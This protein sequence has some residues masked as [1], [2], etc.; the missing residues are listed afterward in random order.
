MKKV[1]ASFAAASLLALVSGAQAQQATAARVVASTT[2]AGAF[3]KAAGATDVVVIAPADF[4][5]PPDYDPRPSDLAAIAGAKFVVMAPFDGFA[6]RLQEAT[7]SAAQIVT[8]DLENTPGKIR[9]EVA[10]LAKIF[11]TETASHAF[12]TRFD[13]EYARL[14]AQVKRELGERKPVVVGHRFMA[15]W[16]DFAGLPIA[17]VYGPRPLQPQELADLVTK[18]PGVIFK[19]GQ[20]ERGNAPSAGRAIAD[21]TGA[22]QVEIL[23][24]PG[25]SL[26]LLEVFEENARRIAAGLKP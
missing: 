17:G 15:Y 21:A 10:R 14:S 2:W 8:V 4:P 3:S 23:N 26:D 20:T 11:G 12:L 7:G 9:S 18:K 1:L 6:K 24:F 16:A 22:R 13:S 19:N 25:K 5:H